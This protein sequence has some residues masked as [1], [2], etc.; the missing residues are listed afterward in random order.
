[1]FSKVQ[2]SKWF[3]REHCF[4]LFPLILRRLPFLSSPFF[5][6]LL[7]RKKALN[8]PWL[9]KTQK[10]KLGMRSLVFY[11]FVLFKPFSPKAALVLFV[12]RHFY[13][14]SCH[15]KRCS[16]IRYLI[17]DTTL[18]KEMKLVKESPAPGG[19]RAH[20]LWVMRLGLY[21]CATKYMCWWYPLS[22]SLDNYAGMCLVGIG[23]IR[24]KVVSVQ[25]QMVDQ[26]ITNLSLLSATCLV[27]T[28]QDLFKNCNFV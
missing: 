4:S 22:S 3:P 14:F 27:K 23:Y 28:H 21:C 5:R 26:A 19:I 7:M 11:S 18:T 1:M 6:R 16:S 20:T 8:T 12:G 10:T 2:A 24:H 13:S 25:V 15:K 17:K 9:L